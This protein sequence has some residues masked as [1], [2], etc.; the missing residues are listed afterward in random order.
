MKKSTQPVSAAESLPTFLD[1]AVAT[2][3]T[4]VATEPD[5][6]EAGTDAAAAEATALEAEPSSHAADGDPANATAP[7]AQTPD[8]AATSEP[9]HKPRNRT[10]PR[11]RT[12]GGGALTTFTGAISLLLGGALPLL[13]AVA[14]KLG[15]FGLDTTT[16]VLGGLVL[17]GAGM[18]ARRLRGLQRQ[19]DEDRTARDEAMSSLQQ[20]LRELLAARHP[21]GGESDAQQ[22]VLLAVQRQ[23]EK[24]NNLTKAIKMYGKPMM[25]IANQGTDL[26]GSIAAVKTL[27]DGGTESTRQ[28]LARMETQ[29]RTQQSTQKQELGDLGRSLQQLASRLEQAGGNG[30]ATLAPLQQKLGQIEVAIAAVSQRLEDNEVRKSLLRLEEVAAKERETLQQLLRGDAVVKA[31]TELQGQLDRATR[32]LT[33]GLTQLRDNNLGGLETAV[34]EIQR[35]VTGVATTVAQINA[36]VKNGARAAAAAPTA[37]A[38]APASAPAPTP[39]P[40]PTAAPAG[41]TPAATAPAGEAGGY[42]TGTR[43]TTGKNVLGAIAKLK[44]MKN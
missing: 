9:A 2:D 25:E 16:L 4:A 21:E 17:C 40:A 38:P 44:Q 41:S 43:A 22:H 23:D 26:A 20:E 39:A 11:P 34:R 36:A 29:L 19:A 32:G 12:A 37:A 35:E 10:A 13:P 8:T 24:V 5:G 27:V 15:A 3:S 28:A 7:A 1:E 30:S 6:S 14:T 31:S 42:Q 33:E 18:Q